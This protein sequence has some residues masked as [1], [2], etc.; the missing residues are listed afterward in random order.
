[1]YEN[2]LFEIKIFE[3]G[4]DIILGVRPMLKNRAARYQMLP[5]AKD[6]NALIASERR[7]TRLDLAISRTIFKESL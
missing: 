4:R 1:M 2:K 3:N 5:A 7:R 6:Y